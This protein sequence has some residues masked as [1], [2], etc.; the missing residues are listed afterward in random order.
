MLGGELLQFARG[1][2][3]GQIAGLQPV[4]NVAALFGQLFSGQ[5]LGLRGGV[6]EGGEEGVDATA[7]GGVRK[8]EGLLHVSDDSPALQKHVE[9]A[10]LLGVESAEATS[11]REVS[12]KAQIARLAREFGH[13]KGLLTA[14]TTVDL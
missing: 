9:Q 4:E 13:L 7:D 14:W 5:G 6:A 8:V 10:A 12:L 11:S 3:W 1:V 2:F